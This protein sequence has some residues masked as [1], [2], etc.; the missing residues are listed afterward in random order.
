MD[1][2]TLVGFWL[3]EEEEG[4]GCGGWERKWKDGKRAEGKGQ[5]GCLQTRPGRALPDKQLPQHNKWHPML[6]WGFL[7]LGCSRDNKRPPSMNGL[8][9]SY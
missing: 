5:L 2:A 1:E 4:L 8:V 6:S 3:E 9:S 7:C